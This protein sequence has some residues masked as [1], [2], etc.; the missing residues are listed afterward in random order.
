M[1]SG[2]TW[3]VWEEYYEL[4]RQNIICVHQEHMHNSMQIISEWKECAKIK[5]E[6][7]TSSMSMTRTCSSELMTGRGIQYMTVFSKGFMLGLQGMLMHHSNG[8]AP[9]VGC[10][11]LLCMTGYLSLVSVQDT[12]KINSE[13]PPFQIN[14]CDIYLKTNFLS[15]PWYYRTHNFPQ[16]CKNFPWVQDTI[17]SSH[18]INNSHIIWKVSDRIV[19][20][21]IDK[22]SE[23]TDW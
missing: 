11:P 16:K 1:N 15:K 7:Q 9:L 13:L 22:Q 2:N 4:H 5:L 17:Q 12:S 20:L 23:K 10:G 21:W 14:H 3:R 18:S 8:S 19:S 6:L